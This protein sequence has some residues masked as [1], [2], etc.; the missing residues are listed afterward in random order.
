MR[1]FEKKNLIDQTEDEIKELERLLKEAKERY[2]K[3]A[4]IS[5]KQSWYDWIWEQLGY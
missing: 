4:K 5:N 1:Y 3:M 2:R